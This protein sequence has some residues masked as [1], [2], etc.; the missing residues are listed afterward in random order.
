MA[1]TQQHY[2]DLVQTGKSSWKAVHVNPPVE[3]KTDNSSNP[4]SLFKNTGALRMTLAE[5]F[6]RLT[7][8][9]IA[10]VLFGVTL[11]TEIDLLRVA[12]FRW[13]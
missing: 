11:S 6:P 1:T 9:L 3:I 5:R 2:F 8:A 12:G 4:E 7:I 10:L 13:Q